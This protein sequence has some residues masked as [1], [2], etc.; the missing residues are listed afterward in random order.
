[1]PG[2]GGRLYVGHND[3]TVEAFLLEAGAELRALGLVWED[4]DDLAVTE[5]VPVDGGAPGGQ[6][7]ILVKGCHVVVV[8]MESGEMNIS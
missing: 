8:T 6:K 1:M 4:R 7:V 5:I 2:G 3:G